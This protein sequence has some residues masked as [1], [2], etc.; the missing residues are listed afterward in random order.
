VTTSGT[1]GSGEG[2]EVVLGVDTH[3]DFHVVGVVLD[4]LGRRLGKSTCRRDPVRLSSA[5]AFCYHPQWADTPLWAV[6]AR[7]TFA[8]PRVVRRGSAFSSHLRRTPL[9][10]TS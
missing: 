8:D 3:L 7:R 6:R 5:D 4:P 9:L 10:R 1:R 2:E